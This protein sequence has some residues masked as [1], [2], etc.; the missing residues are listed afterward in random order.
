MTITELE[1]ELSRRGVILSVEGGR[2]KVD[3]PA[4][5]LTPELREELIH[6]KSMLLSPMDEPATP[7]SAG[8]IDSEVATDLITSPS[9]LSDNP[10]SPSLSRSGRPNF[11][12]TR[13]RSLEDASD[14]LR[15]NH[16]RIVGKIQWRPDP[17]NPNMLHPFVE[18][19]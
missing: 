11:V 14:Y 3:A 19:A 10:T 18:V 7:N 15:Q 5:A 6:Y 13:H 17:E 1:Q 4:G 12:Y 2:L 8:L 16:L 9:T